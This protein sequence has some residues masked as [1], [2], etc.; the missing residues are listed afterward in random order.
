MSVCV[1][2]YLHSSRVVCVCACVCAF[3]CATAAFTV[4]QSRAGNLSCRRAATKRCVDARLGRLGWTWHTFSPHWNCSIM[5]FCLFLMVCLCVCVNVLK[6]R[7]MFVWVCCVY[8]HCHIEVSLNVTR[9]ALSARAVFIYVFIYSAHVCCN[10]IDIELIL[11]SV[12]MY[13]SI[14][15]LIEIL[16]RAL[17]ITC[18][19]VYASLCVCVCLCSSKYILVLILFRGVQS[20]DYDYYLHTRNIRIRRE[21][22]WYK[23]DTENGGVGALSGVLWFRQMRFQFSNI[24]WNDTAAVK[25]GIWGWIEK[26]FGGLA[27]VFL[28]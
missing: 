16:T 24:T 14:L 22:V 13:I 5:L 12:H 23:R 28:F 6:R 10:N 20:H 21:T 3:V 26:G 8:W 18:R 19:I 25:K 7:P 2:T 1:Y 11:S 9:V 17:Y 4:L 15:R 27:I